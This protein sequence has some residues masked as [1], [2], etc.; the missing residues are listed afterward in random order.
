MDNLAIMR[1]ELGF[2]DDELEQIDL[3]DDDEAITK[4][5]NVGMFD[6]VHS[7][8]YINSTNV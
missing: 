3:N 8:D 4:V 7:L 2:T 6:N 1:D 5:P